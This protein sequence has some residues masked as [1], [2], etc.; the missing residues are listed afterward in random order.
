MIVKLRNSILAS[1][2]RT[3]ESITSG[4]ISSEKPLQTGHWRSPNSNSVTFAFGSPR[5]MP[6][7]GMPCSWFF[8]KP[9]SSRLVSPPLVLFALITIRTSTTAT[10]RKTAALPT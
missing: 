4:T 5:T 10:T 1:P 2:A 9:T 3:F 8:T 7:C 6:F